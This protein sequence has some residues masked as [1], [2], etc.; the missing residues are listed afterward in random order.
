VVQTVLEMARNEDGR[1]L[2][3]RVDLTQ[4]VRA[5]YARDYR[6]LE[7]LGLQKYVVQTQLGKR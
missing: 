7:K 5:I 6:S 1:A 3:K 4:P 2:L